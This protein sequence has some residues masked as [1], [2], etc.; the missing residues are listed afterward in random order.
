MKKIGVTLLGCFTYP[1]FCPVIVLWN[2]VALGMHPAKPILG[3]SITPLRQRSKFPQRGLEIA[4][5]V[6]SPPILD[7]CPGWSYESKCHD[8]NEKRLL[9]NVERITICALSRRVQKR[10]KGPTS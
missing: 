7:V 6:S 1:S 3:L 5:R 2:T 9:H 10:Y 4:S 8:E